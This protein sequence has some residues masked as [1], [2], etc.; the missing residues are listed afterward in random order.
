MNSTRKQQRPFVCSPSTTTLS[1]TINSIN[2][3][4]FRPSL[5]VQSRKMNSFISSFIFSSRWSS[6]TEQNIYIHQCS[7]NYAESRK[8][9]DEIWSTVVRRLILVCYRTVSSFILFNIIPFVMIDADVRPVNLQQYHILIMIFILTTFLTHTV[10]LFPMELQFNLRHLATHLGHWRLQSSLRTDSINEWSSECNS[11]IRG[12]QIKCS[13]NH[14]EKY[15][16]GEQ[17]LSNA[18]HPQ[19]ISH[20]IFY[21]LFSNRM[22]FLSKQFLLCIILILCQLLWIIQGKFWYE[23]IISISIIFSTSYIIFQIVRDRLI[24]EM[25]DDNEYNEI[26]LKSKEKKSN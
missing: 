22:N 14:K 1:S 24:F 3:S 8:E 2:R 23:I 9:A 26:I 11:Y 18:A 6:V 12:S 25:M 21:R 13:S 17:L 16:I 10:F 4:P 7:S 5:Q 19:S 15:F 20:S